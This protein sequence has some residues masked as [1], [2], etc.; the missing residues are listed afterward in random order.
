MTKAETLLKEILEQSDNLNSAKE[1]IKKYFLERREKAVWTFRD[2][3][4]IAWMRGIN[5]GNDDIIKIAK[6]RHCRIEVSWDDM[7][8]I[9]NKIKKK[10]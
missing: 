5:V 1:K 9:I 3:K 4:T 10:T 7:I 8:N 6:Q 2:I